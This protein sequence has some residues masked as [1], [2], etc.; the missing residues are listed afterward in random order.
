MTSFKVAQ[1]SFQT[2]ADYPI[3]PSYKCLFIALRINIF[4]PIKLGLS[5]NLIDNLA[6]HVRILIASLSF[7][8]CPLS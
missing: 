6:T 1:V 7:L 3:D 2:Y 5:R 8:L 4:L